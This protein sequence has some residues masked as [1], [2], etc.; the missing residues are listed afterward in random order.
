M[1]D[2]NRNYDNS[3]FIGNLPFHTTWQDLREMF[4]DD[5]SIVRADVVKSHGKLRGMGT[6][7]FA[8]KSD[9]EQAIA[10]FDGKSL[11][12]R[13]IFVR[14]DYPPPEGERRE[15]GE[16]G[17]RGDRPEFG[18]PAKPGCEVFVGNL[19]FLVSWQQLKDLLRP[20]GGLV[21]ADVAERNGRLRGYGT[22][23]FS[24]PEEAQ[25]AIQRF[26]GHV[27]DGRE[28]EVRL[29][30]DIS[31]R[32]RTEVKMN[33]AFTEGVL[34]DSPIA[35]R[36]IYV[37]NLPFITTLTDLFEL[38]QTIGTVTQAEMQ[39]NNYG[40]LNGN[41]VVEFE[42]LELAD[43]AI[44]NLNGYH[45]GGRNLGITYAARTLAPEAEAVEA[46]EAVESMQEDAA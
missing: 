23:V 25:R 34:G 15:R 46:L 17:A 29:D 31:E 8:S 18:E 33:S 3:V 42:A 45:Y 5:F 22:A 20:V 9:V 10:K 30:K 37:A 13:E 11:D 41:A 21:R 14:Q 32:R 19:P 27:M 38:F 6:V 28:I 36:L 26:S 39:Y 1:G 2:S 35:S 44:R 24:T 43:A 40:R 12:G 4:G 7:E 16:R